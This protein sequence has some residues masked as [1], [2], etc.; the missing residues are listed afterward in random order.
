ML[1]QVL[2][3]VSSYNCTSETGLTH[4]T[5]MVYFNHL[6]L[7]HSQLWGCGIT[8]VTCMFAKHIQH[9][10]RRLHSTQHYIGTVW[11]VRV[12]VHCSLLGV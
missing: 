4:L 11:E 6:P 3:I 12:Y 5:T 7:D 9:T 1:L 2:I 8:H 10:I